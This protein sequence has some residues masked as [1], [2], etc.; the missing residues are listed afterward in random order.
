M[1]Q[2]LMKPAARFG[3]QREAFGTGVALHLNRR[4]RSQAIHD[5]N[6]VIIALKL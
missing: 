5:L 6:A 2:I 4:L 3:G 1:A